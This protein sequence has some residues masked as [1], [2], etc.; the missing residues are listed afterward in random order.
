LA[1]ALSAPVLAL[2]D[3][4]CAPLH[5]PVALQLVALVELHVRVADAPVAMLTGAA[6][7]LT[8]G[9]GLV[10]TCR[11]SMALTQ[12]SPVMRVNTRFKVA[13]VVTVKV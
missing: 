1:V 4:A 9:A 5:A 11:T 10:P 2:P 7:R 3:K 6:P 12:A 13:S 8:V